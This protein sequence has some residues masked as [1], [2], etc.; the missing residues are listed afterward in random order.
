M[1]LEFPNTPA[2]G[3]TNAQF[4]YDSAITAWRAQGST[5]N[6][7]TQI[8][9]LQTF[10]ANVV[11]IKNIVPSNITPV[12]GTATFDS[13]GK[14][15]VTGCTILAIDGVFTS[16]YKSY[17][18]IVEQAIASAGTGNWVAMR[19]RA[20]GSNNESTNYYAGGFYANGTSLTNYSMTGGSY[21]E[22]AFVH[23]ANG[24]GYIVMDISN[25][26]AATATNFHGQLSGF[27]G[28]GSN[29][30]QVTGGFHNVAASYDG[31]SLLSLSGSF[32]AVVSI[33]GVN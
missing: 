1:P 19:L 33:Y 26:A 5:N 28:A 30:N 16:K 12:S 17:R 18:I 22:A 9:A 13:L 20:A 6:V 32:S 31:F 2:N 11:G 4:V 25:P 27:N 15:T 24:W 29:F 14:I 8:A 23:S 21:W 3:T 7:G 10:D